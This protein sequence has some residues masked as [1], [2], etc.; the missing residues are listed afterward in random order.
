MYAVSQDSSRAYLGKLVV[1]NLD[2]VTYDIAIVEAF[3]LTGVTFANDDGVRAEV[4]VTG[5]GTLN[6]NSSLNGVS[7]STCPPG[8]YDLSA[9][10]CCRRTG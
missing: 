3:R 7:R 1:A 2:D 10:P 6:L 9:P 8:S 4:S 5:A